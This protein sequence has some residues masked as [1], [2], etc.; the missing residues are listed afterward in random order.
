MQHN[1]LPK[2]IV[3]FVV[4]AR[5][6]ALVPNNEG[7]NADHYNDTRAHDMLVRPSS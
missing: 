3:P 4:V 5:V 1:G 6:R 7:A 2:Q